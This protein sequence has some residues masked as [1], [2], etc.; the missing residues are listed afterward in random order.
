MVGPVKISYVNNSGYTVPPYGVVE[1]SGDMQTL[2]NGE[3]VIPV[4][5]PSGKGPYAI[6]DGKGA[7]ST[8]SGKYG[9]AI[10]PYDN[11]AWVAWDGTDPGEAWQ[12][13]VG[14]IR[15]TFTVGNKGSGYLYAGAKDTTGNRLLVVQSTP[16]NV[17]MVCV[18]TKENAENDWVFRPLVNVAQATQFKAVIPKDY[19]QRTIQYFLD[20]QNNF[21]IVYVTT[22]FIAGGIFTG[23]EFIAAPT[24]ASVVDLPDMK[25]DVIACASPMRYKAVYKIPRTGNPS[26]EIAFNQHYANAAAT[27][28]GC[29]QTAIN[30]TG[31]FLIDGQNV[32]VEWTQDGWH[33]TDFECAP[34]AI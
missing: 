19:T 5:R 32:W 14:P 17:R 26:V 6:D 33:I 11:L 2:A 18:Q 7:M 20:P 15:N 31:R 21:Q 22:R 29:S 30:D 16:K 8:D 3:R 23:N 34:A 24:C 9:T 13:Q 4:T 28:V 1:L 25:W 10:I 27:V 12:D